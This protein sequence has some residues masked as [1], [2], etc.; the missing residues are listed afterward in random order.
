MAKSRLDLRLNTSNS[1]SSIIL[2]SDPP[3]LPMAVLPTIESNPSSSLFTSS[4]SLPT[5][6]ATTLNTC[7]ALLTF[8]NRNSSSM[9]SGIVACALQLVDSMEIPS[10]LCENPLL[11]IPQMLQYRWLKRPEFPFCPKLQRNVEQ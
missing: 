11:M 8:M 1:L 7:I 10:N 4:W 3:P 9:S 5:R 6:P 2:L